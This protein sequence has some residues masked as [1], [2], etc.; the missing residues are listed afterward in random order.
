MK[1][2]RFAPVEHAHAPSAQ[3]HHEPADAHPV[4]RQE[5]GGGAH[6]AGGGQGEEETSAVRDLLAGMSLGE[7][8]VS[9]GREG[10]GETDVSRDPKRLDAQLAGGGGGWALSPYGKGAGSAGVLNPRPEIYPIYI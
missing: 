1:A 5:N 3:A 2:P 6:R 8:S 4:D 10:N 7:T 9:R